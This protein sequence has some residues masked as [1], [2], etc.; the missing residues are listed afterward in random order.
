MAPLIL[1]GNE[2]G[3]IFGFI[4]HFIILIA[5][6]KNMYLAI[7]MYFSIFIAKYKPMAL[8]GR[9]KETAILNKMMASDKP[10]F[11]AVYGRRRIGKTFLI[12]NVFER[13]FTFRLTGLAQATLQEQLA[14][15]NMAMQEQ[16]PQ[17]G[18]KNP[19][20]WMEAFQQIR[21]VVEKSKQKKKVIFIDELPWFDTARAGFVHA[22]EHFWNS[23]ASERKDILL[24]V[25]GSAASWMINTLISNKGGL[26]N[27]VTQKIK[28]EP[29]TLKECKELLAHKKI[30][31]DNYQLMQLYV[32]LGGIPFYW[33]AV[34]KGY[35][36]AQNINKLC[37]ESNGL[38]I[39][40]FNNLFKSLFAKAERHE[41]IVAAIAK[42][43]KGLTREEISVESK[44]ADGGGLTRLLDELQESGFIKRYTP[45]GKKSRNSLYQLT[46]FFS[47]F[48]V[49]FIKGKNT[50]DK[51]H[52]LKMIDSPKQRAWSGY[53]FEQVCL[54]HSPEI[55]KALGIS[56]VETE[57]SMWKSSL[58]PN[59]AQIDLVI[60]RRDG[61]INI[62]EMKFSISPF[63]IDKKYDG[64]L[65]NKTGAFKSETQTK[66]SVF[67]TMITTFGLQTNT[68]SGNVQ[69]DLKMDIL[70]DAV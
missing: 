70:F 11:V 32:V 54:A 61:V 62:C 66:K 16:Y 45:F 36:A 14:N 21:H 42:K 35:S 8:I 4:T 56:G 22:L 47:L 44:L 26:H 52:W 59:G 37:F 33:D 40:E 24:L 65:R 55:K 58:S 64:E 9:Q 31:L 39:T 29:F 49:K 27:R 25:C 41:A 6:Y 34:E 63:I 13:K 48:H 57:I 19:D 53:A 1:L 20:N 28:I 3:A 67:L 12:R 30:T 5:R 17:A 60:D 68:Y 15:F 38:L 2:V 43:G 51:N 10:E 46:D 7:S 69:N 18:R 50:F 23:W